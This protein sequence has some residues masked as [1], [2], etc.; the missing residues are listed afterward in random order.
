[1]ASHLRSASVPSSPCSGET[2][3]E[4]QLQ[5]LNSI[6]SSPS[7][8]LKTM[9]DGFRRLGDIYDCPLLSMPKPVVITYGVYRNEL[10]FHEVHASSEVTFKHDSGKVGKISVDGGILTPQEIVHELEWSIPGNHQVDL[11]PTED[12][13]FK[14]LFPSKADLARMTKIIKVPVPRTCMYLNFEEWS[15]ADI[16]KFYL[17]EVWVR[18]HGCFY[19]E[20]C[21]YLSLFGVGCLIGKTKEVD[22]EFTRAHSVVRMKVEV[23]CEEFI[24][25]T[26]VDHMYDGEGYGL[27]FEHEK[28]PAKAKVDVDMQD[29]NLGDDSKDSDGKGK[30]VPKG[31][32]PPIVG[33]PSKSNS[34][35]NSIKPNASNVSSKQAQNLSMP[36]LRVGLVDCPLTPWNKEVAYSESRALDLVP[37]QLWGDSDNDDED[38]LP[39]PLPRLLSFANEGSDV[40]ARVEVQQLDATA[41]DNAATV[42]VAAGKLGAAEA[43][44]SVDFS[45]VAVTPAVFSGVSPLMNASTPSAL[46]GSPRVL[47]NESFSASPSVET[48]FLSKDL[49]DDERQVSEETIDLPRTS[50]VTKRLGLPHFEEKNGCIDELTGLP[51][52]QIL[53]CKP[54]KRIVVELELERSLALLDLCDAM[55]TKKAQ[56]Q[57]KK[58]SKK[59]SSADQEN[60]R[61]VNLLVEAR[62]AAVMM[63]ES[64]LE[65]L[66]KQIEMPNSSN[67]SL[68][69]KAFQK[70]RVT[71]EEEQL[72]VL[73]L[74]IVDLESRV[75]TLFR[76]LIHSRVSLLNTLSL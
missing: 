61:V 54:Q 30:E 15:V 20:R 32:E 5:S 3:V 29:A 4:G 16:D 58:I 19:K 26:T 17:T 23:T 56:K 11:R 70:K 67:W 2:N 76:R 51:R 75:E 12:G 43:G 57:F 73:E 21:D 74:D 37:R 24:P 72:Q 71:C 46:S 10:I 35:I 38:S 41:A 65:L 63:I 69:S 66:S 39:S 34:V 53:L 55:Q 18:V 25:T 47:D 49:L 50:K 45:V 68:V 7:S 22:M 1:M 33:G 8:T 6:I 59:S 9:L 36:A 62:E 31:L 14:V 27:I 40:S 28:E 52:S 42:S 64:S 13:A 60:C 44:F 48:E